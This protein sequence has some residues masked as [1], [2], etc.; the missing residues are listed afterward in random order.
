MP[1][2]DGRGRRVWKDAAAGESPRWLETSLFGVSRAY[3]DGRERSAAARR[4]PPRDSER[5]PRVVPRRREDAKM[6]DMHPWGAHTL[7][8]VIGGPSWFNVLL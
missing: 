6:V 7:E 5:A 3:A 2:V 8:G 4:R 1:F